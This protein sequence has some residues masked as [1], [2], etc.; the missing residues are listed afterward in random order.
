MSKQ[1]FIDKYL[2]KA[3][4]KKLTVFL[5]ACYFTYIDKL[6]GDQWTVIATSYIGIVA[7]TET[8]L[9]LKSKL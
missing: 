8:V 3:V 2:N 7:F 9:K 1:E 5:I 6:T 4:S